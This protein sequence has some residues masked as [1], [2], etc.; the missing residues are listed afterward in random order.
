MS[1]SWLAQ[2]VAVLVLQHLPTL[3]DLLARELIAE[4]PEQMAA[5]EGV[6]ELGLLVPIPAAAEEVSIRCLV[7]YLAQSF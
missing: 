7:G 2:V 1:M 5:L 6:V 3:V 4:L